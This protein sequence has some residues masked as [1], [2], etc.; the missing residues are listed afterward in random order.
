MEIKI[1]WVKIEQIRKNIVEPDTKG[2]III[3]IIIM[4]QGIKIIN[5]IKKKRNQE[6]YYNNDHNHQ[7]N[8]DEKLDFINPYIEA[9]NFEKYNDFDKLPNLN[10]LK[11][12]SK[13]KRFPEEEEKENKN[14]LLQN[15]SFQNITNQNLLMNQ[16]KLFNQFKL[17][18]NNI[19]LLNLMNNT[20][21]PGYQ[22]ILNNMLQNNAQNS[23][24]IGKNNS[25]LL[26]NLLNFPL[27]LNNNLGGSNLN[28]A[29]IN[30]INNLNNPINNMNNTVMLI[31]QLMNNNN[32]LKNIG[33]QLQP[34]AN[35]KLPIQIQNQQLDNNLINKINNKSPQKNKSY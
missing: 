5:S 32:Q 11:Q 33:I 28:N 7:R 17:G 24:K 9:E 34:N 18:N 14:N 19:N 2:K 8:T 15:N 22:Q 13:Q 3:K 26:P 4:I 30:N 21:L 12:N 31:N 29:K 35:N 10:F 25:Q 27:N 16:L 20:K 6:P 23:N 1:P